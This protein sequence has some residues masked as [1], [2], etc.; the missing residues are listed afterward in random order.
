MASFIAV[1]RSRVKQPQFYWF[2]GHLLTIY[3]FIRFHLSM[4]SRTNQIYHYRWMLIY[5]CLTYGIVNYQFYKSD[6]IKLGQLNKMISKLDNL[7][8]F[9]MIAILLLINLFSWEPNV[10]ISGSTYSPTVFSLFHCLNYFKENLLP[11]LP[12]GRGAGSNRSS[13]KNQ[14]RNMIN[15]FIINYNELFLTIAQIFEIICCLRNGILSLPMTILGIIFQFEW[16]KILKIIGILTYIKFFQLRY[17]SNKRVQFLF[18]KIL[19]QLEMNLGYLNPQLNQIYPI[20]KNFIIN[21]IK[22]L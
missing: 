5:I 9:I 17:N 11:F 15:K 18:Q 14:I 16:N 4:F 13:V 19:T 6:Q 21:L 8:Y 10:M 2:W 12:L 20:V 3:H 1:L 7:Q 22:Y